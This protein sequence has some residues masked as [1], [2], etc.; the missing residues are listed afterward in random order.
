MGPGL[1]SVYRIVMTSAD[2]GTE[3][4]RIGSSSHGIGCSMLLRSSIRLSHLSE[5]AFPNR[6]NRA[7]QFKFLLV[8]RI[9]SSVT[10][11][12]S[13]RKVSTQ[14]QYNLRSFLPFWP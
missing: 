11:D 9:M 10:T 5:A 8:V 3:R 4:Y 12:C 6:R 14:S 7:I 13:L 1:G 2:I